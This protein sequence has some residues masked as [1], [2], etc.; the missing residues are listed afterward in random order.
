MKMTKRLVV[1]PLATADFENWRQAYSMMKPA[2]NEWDESPWKESELMRAKF[3]KFLSE[4]NKKRK[5]DQFYAYGVFRK[6]D[7]VLIGEITLMDVSRGTFQNA[8]L[9]YRIF[10]NYWGKG[11]ASE[12][13][14]A[15]LDIAFKDL[16][17]HRVEAGIAPSN[18]ASIRVAKG[19]GLRREGLSLRRLLVHGK[20]LDLL[21]YAGTCED[22]G[23][24]YKIK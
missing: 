18:K 21:L 10:N 6:D 8:Y 2:Q 5:N 7:G 20:W 4:R 24:R 23:R 15:A 1:R 16:K 19:I 3:R 12:A 9:G 22:F 17:L 14:R 11:Y 13:C